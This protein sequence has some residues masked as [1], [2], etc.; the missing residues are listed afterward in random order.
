MTRINRPPPE[1]H[2]YFG[3]SPEGDRF[4]PDSSTH[5]NWR[6]AVMLV[7]RDTIYL[8]RDFNQM[9]G[10]FV[11]V[12]YQLVT[13]RRRDTYRRMLQEEADELYEAMCLNILPIGDF[14]YRICHI[15]RVPESGLVFLAS[16]SFLNENSLGKHHQ[17]IRLSPSLILGVNL[18]MGVSSR[19]HM[20]S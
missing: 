12:K 18:G 19:T 10:L 11:D 14:G 6:N 5:A 1:L 15:Q 17:N 13:V 16:D 3:C 20:A 4:A 7:V 9:V 8:A 2:F